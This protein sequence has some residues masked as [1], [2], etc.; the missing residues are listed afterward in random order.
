MSLSAQERDRRQ[1][2]LRADMEREKLDVLIV[3]ANSGRLGPCSG[4][5]AYV[6]NFRSFSGQ[7]ALVFPFEEEP[8]L[9]VGVEN[10]RVEALRTSWI[11][12]VRTSV[13]VPDAVGSY[14]KAFGAKKRIGISSL[15][16]MPAAW[17]QQLQGQVSAQAWVEAG[18]LILE[19][20]L[21]K[22]EEEIA[23]CRRAAEVA[24]QMWDHLRECVREGMSEL[25]IRTEMDRAIM[26][27][28]GTENFNMMGLAS[29]T[30]G[31]EAP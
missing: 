28:G 12:D 16:I 15:Q 23:L 1:E 24:D 22:S 17:Y 27:G 20:R 26:P 2:Q 5:L 8:V 4:N 18:D 19:R 30:D 25:E 6:S 13:P 9:F 10:Q 14:L 29:M 31:G 3:Y 7:Q 11:T 21:I